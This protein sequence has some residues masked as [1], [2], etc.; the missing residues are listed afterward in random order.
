M[1]TW[2]TEKVLRWIQQRDSNILGEDDLDN[3]KNTRI[4][5][6]AFL[7]FD[8][9]FFTNCGLPLAV[10]VALKDLTDEVKE[11]SKFIPRT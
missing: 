7:R 3:F 11:E 4:A 5:G 9:E 6:R 1:K 2:D 8:V 10:A